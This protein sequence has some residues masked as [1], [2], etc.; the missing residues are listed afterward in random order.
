MKKT[1]IKQQNEN[2]QKWNNNYMELIYGTL[3]EKY[4]GHVA[5]NRRNHVTDKKPDMLPWKLFVSNEPWK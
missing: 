2:Q 5:N 1:C 4:A 3:E